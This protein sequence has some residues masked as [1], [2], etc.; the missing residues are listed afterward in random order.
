MPHPE[1]F[2]RLVY[3]LAILR[4]VY[5]NCLL[6]NVPHCLISKLQR[7][8]NAAAWLVGCCH[9][10]R[11]ITQVLM[12]L[13]WLSVKQ[14]IQ[15]SI[16]LLVFRVQQGLMNNDLCQHLASN[17]VTELSWYLLHDCGIPFQLRWR[18]PVAS[19]LL[20]LLKTHLSV[21]LISLIYLFLFY[22]CIILYMFLH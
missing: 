2:S 20:R 6:H 1:S 9:R 19:W 21:Y 12:K 11:H 14:C 7:V 3:S 18:K 17:T 4:T 13:H 10:W 22:I 16:L 15:Y 8:Q 5:V